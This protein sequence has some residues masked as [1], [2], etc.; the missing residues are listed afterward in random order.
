MSQI[1]CRGLILF[2]L[3]IQ[4]LHISGFEL[5]ESGPTL[6]LVRVNSSFRLSCR[7]N[8]YYE[9][10]TFY[11]TVS[12]CEFEWK[13]KPWNVTTTDCK[14]FGDRISFQG[15]YN[16]FECAIKIETSVP[17]DT[18]EWSCVLEKYVRGKSRGAGAKVQGQMDVS[19]H[20]NPL[21]LV[22]SACIKTS[23]ESC[24]K[25]TQP[26]CFSE[27]ELF[28]PPTLGM[29]GNSSTG[30]IQ[31]DPEKIEA[32]VNA[33]L[34]ESRIK[35][36]QKDVKTT[37]VGGNS[38]IVDPTIPANGTIQSGLDYQAPLPSSEAN[39]TLKTSTTPSSGANATL[40]ASTTPSSGA[41]ATLKAS[42]LVEL[43]QL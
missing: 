14:D 13:R 42:T 43:M 1:S 30:K 20:S 16:K 22:Q 39:V 25:G 18:G 7:A 11:H 24:Y 5:Q 4:L 6:S 31:D 32:A 27:A 37:D 38:S 35:S 23:L 21:S 28:Q 17:E 41:N 12:K 29:V 15:D 2:I 36:T 33:T 8:S 9:W 3:T 40:K 10:C 26:P 34:E 19:V